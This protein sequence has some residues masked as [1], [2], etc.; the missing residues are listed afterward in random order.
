[1]PYA[2]N[3]Q[4]SQAPIYGGI[5]ITDEQ[6]T[7]ALQAILAGQRVVIEGGQMALKAPEPPEQP[8]PPDPDPEPSVPQLVSRFQALAAL[9]QAGLLD[10]VQAWVDDTDTDPLH[11]LA[12]TTATEFH[13]DSPTLA[14]GAAALGWSDAQLD[15]LF[16]AAASI[17]A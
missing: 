3:D 15:A 1:M 11:R 16:I 13:R 7:A 8:E 10:A 12:F 4:I 2:A 17:K 6:Y 5:E 14:A 9:L